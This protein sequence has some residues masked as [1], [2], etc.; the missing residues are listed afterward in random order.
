[1]TVN[2]RWLGTAGV[3]FNHEGRVILVDPYLSRLGKVD[4][5]FRPLVPLEGALDTYLEGMTGDLEAIV[6]GHTH[7]DHA[8]DIP[9]LAR[10]TKAPVLGCDSLDALLD[11]SGLQGRVT[12]CRP[13]E[14]VSL[15]S[16]ATVTLIPS[17]HGLV[18][19][20]LL[21]FLGNIDRSLSPPL[22]AHRYRLGS[23]HTVKV[24]LGGTTFMH[25]GS[26]GFLERDLEGHRC[27]VLFLCAA[28]WRNTTG[29]PERVIE[30][31]RPSIVVPIHYDDFSLPLEQGKG[32]RILRSADIGIFT[33]RVRAARH[34]L[35]TRRIE[36]WAKTSF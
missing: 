25:V 27:D 19:G 9:G 4:I 28:G 21:L 20:R 16:G 30:I 1:M 31:L 18:L 34:P 35:T 22:R 23:M 26:A 24:E 36:P 15:D 33:E 17:L 13:H 6:C 3:E 10:R 29:Y 12:V 32:I 11:I 5:F 7:F 8:L 2:V 14:P